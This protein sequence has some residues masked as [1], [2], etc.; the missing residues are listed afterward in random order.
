MQ[1]KRAAFV[2]TERAGTEGKP[3]PAPGTDSSLYLVDPE[4]EFIVIYEDK[5]TVEEVRLNLLCMSCSSACCTPDESQ[6]QG[7][8][9]K[10]QTPGVCKAQYLP[11]SWRK[12]LCFLRSLSWLPCR[13]PTASQSRS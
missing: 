4:H 5:A 13:W 1:I 3:E 10:L 12:C 8:Q 6:L 11:S 2:L 9:N 7:S